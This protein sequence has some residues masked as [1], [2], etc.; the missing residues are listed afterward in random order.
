MVTIRRRIFSETALALALIEP[1]SSG[2]HTES[3]SIIT[4]KDMHTVI[5]LRETPKR[6]RRF[7]K[8]NV[9]SPAFE[10]ELRASGVKASA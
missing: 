10:L 1:H 3:W 9:C 7:R 5:T 6:T 2:A 8:A 4:V